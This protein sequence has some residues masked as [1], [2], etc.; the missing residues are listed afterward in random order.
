MDESIRARHQRIVDGDERPQLRRSI[1]VAQTVYHGQSV[2]LD[3]SE[4][5]NGRQNF[6]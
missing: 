1:L 4:V 2:R 6:E 3:E 5:L